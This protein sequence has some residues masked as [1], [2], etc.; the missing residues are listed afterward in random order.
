M[1]T[2][3]QRVT[4][5]LVARITPEAIA[6]WKAGD[7]GDLQRALRLPPWHASPLDVGGDQ[8]AGNTAGATTWA[9]ATRLRS[10]LIALAGEQ[11]LRQL[12]TNTA[13]A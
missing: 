11:G 12:A 6:A 8:P 4:R 7:W 2:K 3:R 5:S 9:E 1:P 13:S 10:E